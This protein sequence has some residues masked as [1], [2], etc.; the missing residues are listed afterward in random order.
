[1]LL[2]TGPNVQ[3]HI[4]AGVTDMRKSMDGFAILIENLL[5]PDP[6]SGHL[7]AFR[8]RTANL[9]KVVLWHG[10][11]LRLFTKRLS[12]TNLS[13]DPTFQSSSSTWGEREKL[14]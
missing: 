6:F 8:G 10:K 1:M 9:I 5:R 4:A 3:I 11:G 2:P 13:A 7:F 12:L 14:L